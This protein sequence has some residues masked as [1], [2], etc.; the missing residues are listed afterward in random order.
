MQKKWRL[1]SSK[2]LKKR[3]TQIDEQNPQKQKQWYLA[4]IHTSQMKSSDEEEVKAKKHEKKFSRKE[5][6]PDSS[7]SQKMKRNPCKSWET[8]PEVVNVK[9]YNQ[10]FKNL[11]FCLPFTD[12]INKTPITKGL[13]DLRVLLYERTEDPDEH[14]SNF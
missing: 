12:D 1:K 11:N 9:Q 5:V 14:V 8:S 7:R 13:K 2:L 3:Q 6:S 10:T 4:S